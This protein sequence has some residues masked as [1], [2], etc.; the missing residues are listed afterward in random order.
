MSS[1]AEKVVT[2]S[3]CKKAY[4]SKKSLKRHMKKHSPQTP[5]VRKIPSNSPLHYKDM[6]EKQQQQQ[7]EPPSHYNFIQTQQTTTTSEADMEFPLGANTN[8]FRY[9][10]DIYI[11]RKGEDVMRIHVPE[12]RQ[13]LDIKPSIASCIHDYLEGKKVKFVQNLGE[14]LYV[15]IQ[16]PYRCVDLRKFWIIPNTEQIFPTKMGIPLTFTEYEELVNVLEKNI[17]PEDHKTDVTDSEGR[18]SL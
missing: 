8:I 7:E 12:L 18:Q 1:T 2:C 6:T 10:K 14:D 17:F 3:E 11:L 15:G 16:S 9:F 13:L 4:A 5:Y